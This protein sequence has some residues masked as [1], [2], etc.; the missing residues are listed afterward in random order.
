M[1]VNNFSKELMEQFEGVIYDMLDAY[2]RSNYV[3]IM[4]LLR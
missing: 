1:K 4:R 2:I 3:P